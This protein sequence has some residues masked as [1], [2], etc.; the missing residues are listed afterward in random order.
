MHKIRVDERRRKRKRSKKRLK[1]GK[2]INRIKKP[3]T[4]MVCWY[5]GSKEARKQGP[6]GA[7]RIGL[8]LWFFGKREKEKETRYDRGAV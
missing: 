3:T 7:R 1:R 2:K 4:C 5:N 6:R 8:I